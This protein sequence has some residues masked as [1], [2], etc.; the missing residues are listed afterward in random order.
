MS[1]KNSLYVTCCISAMT[2]LLASWNSSSSVHVGFRAANW[3]AT[4]L[5]SRIHTVCMTARST[6]SLALE[7]PALKQV[8]VRV[9]SWHSPRL[10]GR[11]ERPLTFWTLKKKQT[12]QDGH[13]LKIEATIDTFRHSDQTPWKYSSK[14]L[15]TSCRNSK[16]PRYHFI[17]QNSSYYT[18]VQ[19]FTI[20]QTFRNIY[21][22]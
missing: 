16:L 13:Y 15:S 21:N 20:L 18:P 14:F 9:G 12:C 17:A 11:R 2:I 7:S 3:S 8:M 1:G 22:I 5:C 10:L 6:C 19:Y 4:L